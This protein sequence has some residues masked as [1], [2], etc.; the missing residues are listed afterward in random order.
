MKSVHPVVK[1]I[2]SDY[3]LGVLCS[4]IVIFCSLLLFY[5]VCILPLWEEVKELPQ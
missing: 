3:F 5:N 1:I 4:V 2:K